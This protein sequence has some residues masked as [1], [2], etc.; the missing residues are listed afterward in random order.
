MIWNAIAPRR[1]LRA[2][3]LS[4]VPLILAIRTKSFVLIPYWGIN[5]VDF[6]ICNFDIFLSYYH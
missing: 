3:A 6:F 5:T 4:P 2:I 1:A